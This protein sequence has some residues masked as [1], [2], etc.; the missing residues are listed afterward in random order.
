MYKI[1]KFVEATGQL[2]IKFDLLPIPTSID[3]PVENNRYI[4]G[5]AL[6]KYIEGFNPSWAT[7]RQKSINDGIENVEYMRSLDSRSP[8]E[9]K[10]DKA[11]EIRGI[12]DGRL[13]A[14]DWLMLSD[15]GFSDEAIIRFKKFRQE[16]R[17]VP[18]Q[19]GFPYDV[20]WPTAEGE[21]PNRTD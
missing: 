12:R 21:W 3:V 6:V 11:M 2:V 4:E 9:L 16:L 17:D 5:D 7:A 15:V 13:R 8:E 14:S 18:Q 20:V 19:L 1:L 10:R